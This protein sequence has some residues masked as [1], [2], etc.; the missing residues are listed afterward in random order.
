MLVEMMD[1]LDGQYPEFDQGLIRKAENLSHLFGGMDLTES[2]W[3][4]YLNEISSGKFPLEKLPEHVREIAKELYY[5]N[6]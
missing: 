4:F 2:S 5:K 3:R 6:K 1:D